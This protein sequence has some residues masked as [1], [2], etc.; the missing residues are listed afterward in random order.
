MILNR[1]CRA[2]LDCVLRPR[3]TCLVAL[4]VNGQHDH[5][6]RRNV[7]AQRGIFQPPVGEIP[8]FLLIHLRRPQVRPLRERLHVQQAFLTE[9]VQPFHARAEAVLLRHEEHLAVRRQVNKVLVHRDAE[10]AESVVQ[11]GV[12]VGEC[13]FVGDFVS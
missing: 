13:R 1:Q 11:P 2:E 4:R 5:I 7:V 6:I 10:R 3:K 8:C 9:R 12:H